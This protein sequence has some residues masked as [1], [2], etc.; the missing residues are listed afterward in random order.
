MKRKPLQLDI[1]KHSPKELAKAYREAAENALVSDG[2]PFFTAQDRYA[3]FMAEAEHYERVAAIDE[4][5]GR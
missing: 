4:S 3:R 2:D 5:Q 1:F